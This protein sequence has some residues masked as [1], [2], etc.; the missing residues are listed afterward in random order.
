MVWF[1]EFGIYS[2]LLF[3]VVIFVVVHVGDLV[4]FCLSWLPSDDLVK[5]RISELILVHFFQ[6]E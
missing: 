3:Y 4:S 5:I 6:H 1:V 2:K